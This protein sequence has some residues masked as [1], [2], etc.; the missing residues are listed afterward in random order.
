MLRRRLLKFQLRAPSEMQNMEEQSLPGSDIASAAD[1]E[2][3]SDISYMAATAS[4]SLGDKTPLPLQADTEPSPSEPRVPSTQPLKSESPPPILYENDL[5]FISDGPPTPTEKVR[6]VQH[7]GA[8]SFYFDE[9][10]GE[11]LD[12]SIQK[13]ASSPKKDLRSDFE[14]HEQK[15]KP[16]SFQNTEENHSDSESD[17]SKA[18]RGFRGVVVDTSDDSDNSI[19]ELQLSNELLE[20]LQDELKQKLALA[21]RPS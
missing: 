9:K 14:E 7:A 3:D 15:K 18:D 19:D 10:V 13:I 11:M 1:A 2:P 6:R 4:S 17:E 8:K 5:S 16:H 21:P 12:S 20:T